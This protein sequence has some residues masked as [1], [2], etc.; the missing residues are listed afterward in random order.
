M[1]SNIWRR[2]FLRGA[3]AALAFLAA[4]QLA[5]ADEMTFIL[6]CSGSPCGAPAAGSGNDSTI[7]QRGSSNS[8]S[9]E[10]QAILAVTPIPPPSSRRGR[11]T[12]SA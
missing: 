8:A 5:T 6:G 10:Q 9:V 1:N 7:T 12:A 3:A 11:A 2:N 4:A